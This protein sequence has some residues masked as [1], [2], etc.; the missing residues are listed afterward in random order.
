MASRALACCVRVVAGAAAERVVVEGSDAEMA[1]GVVAGALFA[2]AG[3]SKSMS[4]SESRLRWPIKEKPGVEYGS[5]YTHQEIDQK[6]L[7]LLFAR[8]EQVFEICCRRPL[9][10]IRIR[11][12]VLRRSCRALCLLIDKRRFVVCPPVGS[13]DDLKV[14]DGT[15]RTLRGAGHRVR[16]RLGGGLVHVRINAL[17]TAPVFV[18]LAEHGVQEL[19]CPRFLRRQVCAR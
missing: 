13:G 11:I 12:G 2:K 7:T 10:G 3:S 14:G 18:P 15:M 16:A 9:D 4:S 6:K 1:I 19:Q 8:R 17:R 5:V